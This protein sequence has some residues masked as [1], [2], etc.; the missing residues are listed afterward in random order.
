MHR[1]GLR[2][3]REHDDRQHR[4]RSERIG[5]LAAALAAISFGAAFPATAVVL[6]AYTPLAAAAATYS[7][8]ALLLM[9]GLAVA[10]V[11]PRPGPGWAAPGALVRL[12]AVACWADSDSSWA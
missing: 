1:P 5:V 9:V 11:I 10:G 12:G 7:T 4:W 6:R 8:I 2:A 3:K